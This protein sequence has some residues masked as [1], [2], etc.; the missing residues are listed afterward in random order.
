MAAQNHA[1]RKHLAPTT[2]TA[3]MSPLLEQ[4]EN[5]LLLSVN[6]P[7]L[8]LVDQTIDR[9]DGQVIYLNDRARIRATV[10]C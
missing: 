8:Q 1:S 4:L 3:K 2:R 5:R 7:G 10:T 9:F 6:L